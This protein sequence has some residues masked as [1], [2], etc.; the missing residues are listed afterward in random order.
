MGNFSSRTFICDLSDTLCLPVEVVVGEKNY[1]VV[2]GDDGYFLAS[3]ICP[4]QGG[5][6][7]WEAN[8]E[9][10][11]CPLHNWLFDRCGGGLNTTQP[12]YLA[13]LE[14]QGGKLWLEDDSFLGKAKLKSKAD[15][16]VKQTLTSLGRQP[17]IKIR[18]LSHASLQISYQDK[19]LVIDPWLEGP[20]MLGA[21][22]QY[23]ITNI[24]A[25]DISPSAVIITHEHSDHFHLPTLRCF[26]R[27]TPIYIP[28]F[29]NER[30][31]EF[32]RREG[33]KELHVV[34]FESLTT[35]FPKIQLKY[36][37][38]VS[39]F[40][41]SIVSINIDGYKI[42]NLNDAGLNQGIA[43]TV[44]P[45]DL[46]TCIFSTGASGYPLAWEHIDLDEKIR[47][48]ERACQGRLEMLWE[49]VQLYRAN[50]IMPF[51]SHVR[52]WHPDHRQYLNI[53]ITNHIGNVV[54]FFT[55]QGGREQLVDMI[56][57]DSFSVQDHQVE[58]AWENRKILYDKD[59][60]VK[61]VEADWQRN[62]DR[63]PIKDLWGTE[64][65]DPT[66]DQVRRYFLYLN[67][68]PDI[69]YCESLYLTFRCMTSDWDG[70]YFSFN[71]KIEDQKI[72][73]VQD[74]GEDL[75]NF[76]MDITKEILAPILS[77]NLSWDE[78]RVGY[79]I[80]WWRNTDSVHT[81]FLRLLQGPF[82]IRE[83]EKGQIL[84]GEINPATSIA[85][86]LEIHGERAEKLLNRYG[87]YCSGCGLSPWE[88]IKAGAEKHGLGKIEIQTL[89]EAIAKLQD[90]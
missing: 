30:I 62:G 42:L 66:K 2:E 44:G 78:A 18:L 25:D 67:N 52:L 50:Y 6:I 84:Q 8:E 5:K 46:V 12:M 65:I 53:L 22:R 76:R 48:M 49:A 59:Y 16:P 85:S 21:W 73:I 17:K 58:Q 32:L 74:L 89:L 29:E 69:K 14:E 63:F 68:N 24:S 35:I 77:G 70:E 55:K 3:K 9:C 60:L 61:S 71:L 43:D 83:P 4:H 88:S 45:V 36:Y 26:P 82:K 28:A 11:R 15:A 19:E 13:P 20:A 40:N 38:P 34:D 57:G 80:R 51:A 37:R 72:S 47:I 23:P 39:V 90:E 86:L 41:D 31:E 56:P 79:W 33:F 1:F 10:F 87:L 81:G 27:S 7:R 54:E 75:P 64:M